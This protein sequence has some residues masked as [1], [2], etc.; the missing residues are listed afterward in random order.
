VFSMVIYCTRFIFIHFTR[1]DYVS[2]C[3]SRLCIVLCCL[4]AGH[5]CWVLVLLCERLYYV[6]VSFFMKVIT[7]LCMCE[8][9]CVSSFDIV[10]CCLFA[11]YRCYVLVCCGDIFIFG[12]LFHFYDPSLLVYCTYA[13]LCKWSVCPFFCLSL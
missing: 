2:S 8:Y 10:L 1:S 11:D 7:F 13:P 9:M 6:S 4:F 5:R 3:V 12:V